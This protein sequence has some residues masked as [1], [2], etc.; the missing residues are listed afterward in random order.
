VVK[1]IRLIV[2]LDI[3]IAR[4]DGRYKR[5]IRHFF[6]WER[7]VPAFAVTRLPC[8]VS[9]TSLET[10]LVSAVVLEALA[11]SCFLSTGWSTIPLAVLAPSTH[12]KP[13]ATPPAICSSQNDISPCHS[14]PFDRGWTKAVEL[15]QAVSGV[16]ETP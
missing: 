11:F 8:R 12:V 6:C 7:I 10:V 14:A 3:Q 9:S 4:I 1:I 13:L 15:W 16:V 5:V 2:L